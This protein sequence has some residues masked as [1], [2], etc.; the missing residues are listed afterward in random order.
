MSDSSLSTNFTSLSL[1]TE[2]AAPPGDG[3]LIRGPYYGSLCL[4][5]DNLDPPIVPVLEKAILYSKVRAF[6]ESGVIFDSLSSGGLEDNPTILFERFLDYLNQ[7]RLFDGAKILEQALA[8]AEPS[9][10]GWE[11][12]GIY[13]L[14]RIYLAQIE[15]FTKGDFTRASHAMLE[16][17][18]WLSQTPIEKYT[19]IQVG[20]SISSK[21]CG[22]Q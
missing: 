9:L 19:E 6:A 5:Y 14:I 4:Q 17:R 7:W 18:N 1:G 22:R 11:K 12:T 10:V 2:H 21:K 8:V 20:K 13:I 16:V 15:A 3:S